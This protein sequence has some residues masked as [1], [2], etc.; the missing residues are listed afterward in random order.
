M[1]NKLLLSGYEILD[2]YFEDMVKNPDIDEDLRTAII[3][4][5]KHQQLYTKTHL[6]RALAGIIEKKSNE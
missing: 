1:T 5:W 6:E 3:E 4:L 2:K